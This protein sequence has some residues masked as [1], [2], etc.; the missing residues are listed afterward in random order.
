M[1]YY[2]KICLKNP[3]KIENIFAIYRLPSRGDNPIWKMPKMIFS[4]SGWDETKPSSYWGTPWL[5]KPSYGITSKTCWYLWVPMRRPKGPCR[6]LTTQA[7][8]C[9]RNM[10][11]ERLHEKQSTMKWWVW[12]INKWG[13]HGDFS[14][15]WWNIVGELLM[16]IL[17]GGRATPTKN[18]SS[19]FGTIWVPT[20][21]KNHPS[22]PQQFIDC[23][24]SVKCVHSA[25]TD[26]EET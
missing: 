19:S 6:R 4:K 13:L 25:Y 21:W 11:I 14:N 8:G 15:F 2:T 17:V 22:K 24:I 3:W 1:A 23:A 20:E 9:H 7:Y 26:F 10:G 12:T 18:M 5:W 16:G